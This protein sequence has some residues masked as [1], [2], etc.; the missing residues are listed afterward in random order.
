MTTVAWGLYDFA[1]GWVS[2]MAIEPAFRRLWP[3]MLTSWVRLIDGR[4]TDP[5]VG[6]DLLI[7]TL[8]G[9]STARKC[10]CPVAAPS[11]TP[12]AC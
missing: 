1:Y 12:P 3:R 5:R 9:S 2:Y 6:R 4:L 10:C 11:T 7:G 8:T